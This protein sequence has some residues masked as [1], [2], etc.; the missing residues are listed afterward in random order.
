MGKP[1]EYLINECDIDVIEYIEELEKAVNAIA[2]W[3]AA[4]LS[5]PSATMC[6]EY[7]DAC[8]LI[9]KADLE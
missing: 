9:F 1:K 4:S 2:P 5:D 6:K 3:L 8:E 7:T